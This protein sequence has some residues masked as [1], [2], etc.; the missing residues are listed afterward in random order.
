MCSDPT[1]DPTTMILHFQCP[2][3][4]GLAGLKEVWAPLVSFAMLHIAIY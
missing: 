1:F 3:A 2:Y 4:K